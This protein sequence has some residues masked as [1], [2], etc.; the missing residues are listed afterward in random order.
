MFIFTDFLAD[1]NKNTKEYECTTCKNKFST[2]DDQQRHEC[3]HASVQQLQSQSPLF[4]C[5][6]CHKGFT[7]KGVFDQHERVHLFKGYPFECK[8]CGKKFKEQDYLHQHQKKFHSNETNF[9]CKVCKQW[10]VRY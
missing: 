1:V 7:S 9:E 6:L 5:K 8:I 2:A 4:V 3:M 10:Y